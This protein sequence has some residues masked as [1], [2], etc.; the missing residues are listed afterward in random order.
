MNL[1]NY[2]E[3]FFDELEIAKYKRKEVSVE[4]ELNQISM[5]RVGD[6]AVTVIR[7]IKDKKLGIFIVDSDDEGE[8]KKGIEQAA[9]NAMANEK[10]EKWAGLPNE[11][12]YNAPNIEINYEIKD[13]SPDFFV[14]LLNE[15]IKD[16]RARDERAMVAGGAA[17]GSWLEMRISNS[18][19][20]DIMEEFGSTFM[21][22][23]VVGRVG[24]SVTPG[25][26]DFDV[27]RD[28]NLDKEL[29]VSSILE[30]LK[31]AYTTKKSDK[32]EGNV[33]M[34][35][36]ALAEL[37]YFTLIPAISGERKVKNTT[38]LSDKVG[39]KVLNKKITIYDD[40]W[41]PMSTNP[42]VAD[43]EG[44]AARVNKI[45]ENGVFNGFLWD[46]YWG[47]ISGYG[48]TGNG[49]RN[50]STG[51]IGIG[52]HNLVIEGGN[53]EKEGLMGEIKDGFLVS[54]FQGAHS[55]NPDTGDFSVVANPAF[56]IENGEIV[57]ST[58]FMLSGNVY[59]LL[60]NV[61][62]ISREQRKIVV[63]GNG[64]MP[65]MLFENLKIAPVSR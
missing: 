61:A 55:S 51:G 30:K 3:K 7:G 43:D 46:N 25:I 11:Q 65:H 37:L 34:E 24:N 2:G 10:D 41:H 36:L 19:G 21:Y 56:K 45:F 32:N 20:I 14:N 26:M 53:K 35:P 47:N 50:L 63:M 27:R 17:G 31:Y 4:V 52:V 16:V 13:A 9:K 62:D 49:T 59:S 40:P 64:V 5:S 22:L 39:Q 33:I 8:I 38:P 42:I 1:I 44:V 57:G 23:Y 15:A 58:V 54:G 29:I 18:H 60:G 28:M 48:S 6:R 12:K